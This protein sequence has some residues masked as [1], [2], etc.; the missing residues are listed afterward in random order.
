M[1][2]C[3]SI[4]C[5]SNTASAEAATHFYTIT[6]DDTLSRLSVEAHFA[7]PID[8]ITARSRHA[9]RFLLDARECGDDENF[10]LHNRRLMFPDKG[11]ACLNYTVDLERA[12]EEYRF[13][14]ELSARNI[15]ASPSLWL[16][17]PRLRNGTRI[18]ARF[19]LPTDVRVSVP[20]QAIDAS[21]TEFLFGRSPENASSPVVFGRF[22]Y[23]EID[24][25]GSTLRVSLVE[26]RT[27]MDNDAIADWVKATAMDVSLAYGRFPSPSPQ[28]VVVPV[29]GSRSAVAFGQV[30]RDG[31]ETVE[32]T[33]DPDESLEEYL[34]DWKATHEFSHLMLP[35]ITRAQRW[36]SEGFA[37]YYQNVL[38]AKAGAYDETYAWQK[39]YDGLE[40][41]RLSRPE[42]SPNEAASKGDRSGGMKV[43]WSGAALALIADVELRKRS[44]GEEG[45]SDVLGRFQ[46]CCLP[47]PDIWSGPEFFAKLDTLISQP[48]FMPL[49]KKYA[50]T[51]GFPDTSDLLVR[52]GVSMSGGEISLNRNAELRSIRDSITETDSTTPPWRSA[53]SSN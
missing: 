43:Y 30:I 15:V 29:A 45:L 8:S 6:V 42:L 18:R 27:P 26:G 3:L 12:A 13:A 38:L 40:R 44:G 34:S 22:D 10:R 35:Y 52:L 32:L 50:N 39:I 49:Y 4:L 7:H 53:L 33:V 51:A 19:H 5:C 47:S 36:I 23:R 16:W 1:L 11:I 37:Q 21:G 48:L 17:R 41:G 28:V 14:R 20:W 9:R 31:G 46:H 2:L 24:I 25:P